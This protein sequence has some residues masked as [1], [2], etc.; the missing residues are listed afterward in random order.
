MRLEK[1]TMSDNKPAPTGIEL[2]TKNM[3]ELAREIGEMDPDD[4]VRAERL[5]ELFA[6]KELSGSLE[7]ETN[8]LIHKRMDELAREIGILKPGDP[9]RA[10]IVNEILRLNDVGNPLRTE[11]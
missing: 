10:Q 3:N 7:S 6:L 9:R 5:K 4:S 1:R 2:L 11:S 8:E